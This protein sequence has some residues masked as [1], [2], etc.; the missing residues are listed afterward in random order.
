[1]ISILYL[2]IVD[3]VVAIQYSRIHLQGAAKPQCKKT[4]VKVFCSFPEYVSM[5]SANI[6][7]KCYNN[8][9]YV[10]KF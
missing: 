9:F 4:Q 7:S 6:K 3:P 8:F 10:N 2:S 5:I 1:M